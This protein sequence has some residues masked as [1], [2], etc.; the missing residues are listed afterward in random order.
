MTNKFVK[1]APHPI[2]TWLALIDP[3]AQAQ[4]LLPGE[5]GV[6]AFLERLLQ[7][8]LY[9]DGI[10]FLAQALPPREAVWWA[11]LCV[12]DAAF[13]DAPVPAVVSVLEAA[14]HW[15][16]EPNEYNRRLAMSMAEKAGFANPASWTGVAAFWSGGSLA[17]EGAPV[18]PPSEDLKGRAVAG[19]IL[20]AAV[21]KEPEKMED[22]FRLFLARAFDIA[23]GGNGR[24]PRTLT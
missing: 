17:P 1:I 2:N 21:H 5:P 8:G 9:R 11:C 13:D 7:A 22:K 20:L 15:V 16:Y 14:E 3:S 4:A 23:C 6:E 24:E 10:A 18:V 19:A 12:R